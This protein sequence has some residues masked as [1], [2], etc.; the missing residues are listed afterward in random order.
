M[1]TPVANAQASQ[2]PSELQT[3]RGRNREGIL[4]NKRNREFSQIRI[5]ICKFVQFTH[6]TVN[7]AAVMKL[8]CQSVNVIITDM[9]RLTSYKK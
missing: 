6:G 3:G 9:Y 7:E 2:Q 4:F 1:Y 5:K 8:C